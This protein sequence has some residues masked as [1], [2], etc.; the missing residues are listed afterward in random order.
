VVADVGLTRSDLDKHATVLHG[1]AAE[2]PS[3]ESK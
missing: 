1:L 3:L 2:L